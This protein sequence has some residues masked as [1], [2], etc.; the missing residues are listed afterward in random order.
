V[1]A[2]AVELQQMALINT[3]AEAEAVEVL[4]GKLLQ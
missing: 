2:Q 1:A 3:L 4:F